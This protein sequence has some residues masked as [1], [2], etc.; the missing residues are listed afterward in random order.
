MQHIDKI[1][2]LHNLLKTRRTPISGKDIDAK[3]GLSKATRQR[4]VDALRD[5][6][7]AP[8]VCDRALGGYFYDRNDPRHPFELPGI[9]FTAEELQALIACQQLLGNLTPG[10][11]HNEIDQ[12]SQHLK[13]L[14]TRNSQADLSQLARIKILNQA[15]RHGNDNLFLQIVN[16]LFSEHRLTIDYHARSDDSISQRQVSPQALVRYRDNWYLDA[17]CHLRQ[18]PRSFALD[19]I[20]TVSI[21]NQ[22]AHRLEADLLQQHFGSAYGIFAGT[23]KHT[24]ILNFSAQ[25]ARWVADEHWHSQQQSQWLTD[26]RYQLR[27]PFNRHEELL[28]DILKYGAEVEVVEPEFLR[29]LVREA[30]ERMLAVYR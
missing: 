9:W 3:L 2:K 13:K 15:Y 1:F 24:A 8:L 16:S 28:M 11:F 22:P 12:L 26:G 10:L 30:V 7:N 19:R 14:L 25:A 27:I 17:Y 4:L 23:P 18:Q 5:H 20:R 6:L 21:D 29:E